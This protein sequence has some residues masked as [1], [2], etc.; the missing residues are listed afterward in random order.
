MALGLSLGLTPVVRALAR[1][2]G[3]LCYPNE[4]SVHR[5][6]VPYLGGVS[7]YLASVLA[8]SLIKSPKDPVL[9]RALTYGGVFILIVGLVDD[10][11]GLKPWQKA[12]GQILSGVLV[13]ALRINISFVSDPWSNTVKVLGFLAVPVTLFWIVSFENLINFS[14]GLDG[15]AAGVTAIT[16]TVIVFAANKAGAPKVCPVAAAIAGSVLGFLPYNFHPASIFMGDAGALYLGL[17][18]ASLS[19]QGLV[20]SAVLMSVF[21]PLLALLIPISD[22]AF[23]IIRR[24]SAGMPASRADR[25]HLH[26]RLLELGL[27]HRQCVYIIYFVSMGFGALG[28]VASFI[29]LAQGVSIAGVAVVALLLTMHRTGLLSVR[30]VRNRTDDRSST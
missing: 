13:L 24:R 8:V 3:A 25:D 9:V 19:I 7:I 27:G 21:A 16:A 1:K 15:L 29:P 26:H 22:A 10:L 2:T 23:A 5:V 4:R 11:V 28:L 6:P 30:Q 17:A 20:K 12:L 14:D 18:L